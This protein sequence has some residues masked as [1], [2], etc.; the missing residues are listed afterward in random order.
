M[1]VKRPASEAKRAGAADKAARPA[2]TGRYTALSTPRWLQSAV[3]G[4]EPGQVVTQ[5]TFTANQSSGQGKAKAV[6]AKQGSTVAKKM[7]ART[8]G[9]SVGTVRETKKSTATGRYVTKEAQ[10]NPYAMS[11]EQV[12]EVLRKAKVLTSGGRLTRVFK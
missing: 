5:A 12:F 3:V 8:E 6:R 2:V 11:R 9:K 1:T 4:T 7:A 10:P